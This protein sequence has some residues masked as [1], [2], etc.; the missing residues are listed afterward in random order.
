MEKRKADKMR[1]SIAAFIIVLC[2]HAN[3][4]QPGPQHVFT[5]QENPAVIEGMA[6]DATEGN[7]YFG[8]S[9]SLKILRYTKQGKPSGF[10][11]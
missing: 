11:D 5:L 8:E 2:L 1:F 9:I 7:F 3:A 4:Q 6:Y 10:I